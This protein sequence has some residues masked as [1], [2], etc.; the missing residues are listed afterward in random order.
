V[1]RGQSGRVAFLGGALAFVTAGCL[2]QAVTT[3]AQD[4]ATTYRIFMLVAAVVAL[5]V[6]GSAT[7]AIIRYRRRDD[8]DTLPVQTRG[9][10]AAEAIWTLLPALTVVGLFGLTFLTLTRVDPADADQGPGNGAEYAAIVE[11]TAFR[12]GWTFRYPDA[13]VT[14]SGI[15]APGPE[16]HVPVGEPV[17]FR[18]SSA[19]VIHSFYVPHF[20]QKRDAN[21]GRTNL[22]KVTIEESGT[23][24]GQC[25]EF[26][27]LY[28]HRMPFAVLAEP[29]ADFDAWLSAQPRGTDP[30]IPVGSPLTSDAPAQPS[31]SEA[32]QPAEP[33]P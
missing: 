6:V 10:V 27:G 4:I 17:L 9:N 7:F 13:D 20:L 14:I 28:H 2:P 25:A 12:W 24:R 30:D 15:G 32:G 1:R 33:A 29:R 23:Y 5:I 3:E 18:I 21:P 26:C 8:D 22:L 16:I 31:A 11:V 19:D